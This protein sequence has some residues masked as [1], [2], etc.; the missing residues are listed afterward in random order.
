MKRLVLELKD[1]SA[2]Y[3]AVPDDPIDRKI[4]EFINSCNDPHKLSQLF[5]RESDGVYQFG[6][7]RIYVKFEQDKVFIRVGGG[8]LSLEEFLSTHV[9]LELDKLRRNDPVK[10]LSQ[11]IAVQKTIA[12]RSIN[13][14]DK[15][16]TTSAYAYKNYSPVLHKTDIEALKK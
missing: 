13:E 12:G 15:K 16:A 14:N 4:A 1:K 5:L 2:V 7:K 11:N 8:F 10:I 9:P 3:V 6:T